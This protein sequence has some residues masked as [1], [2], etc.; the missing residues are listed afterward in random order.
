VWKKR[1]CFD[2]TVAFLSFVSQGVVATIIM[3]TVMVG[4]TGGWMDQIVIS[5]LGV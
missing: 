1:T 4:H 3:A 5:Y 2:A